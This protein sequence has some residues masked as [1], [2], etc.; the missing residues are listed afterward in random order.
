MEAVNIIPMPVARFA[1]ALLAAI[2]GIASISRPTPPEAK[3]TKRP[4][5]IVILADDLGFSDIGSYGG[6]IRTPNL[7]GLA[8]DGVRMSQFYN[9]ARCCPT[10]AS[11]LTG[12]YP[13]Q[14][15]MGEM[16]QDR[17]L[18]AYRGEINDKCAT[19]AEVLRE[20]G[21]RTGMAGK[22]H[23]T[24]LNI[25]SLPG[26]QQKALMN[27]EADGPISPTKA[28][29][30]FNR[31]FEEHWGTIPGVDSF[32]DPYGLVHNETTLRPAGKNFY[33]TDFITQHSVGMID[34]F[35]LEKGK[36]FFLYV[37][38]TAPHWPIQAKQ[39]DIDRYKGVYDVGWDR[40]RENRY[41]R[42]LK[43]GLI[44][45]DWKLSP[46]AFNTG[47]GDRDSRVN[48]W[49]DAPNKDWEAGRM[50]AYAAMVETM[51]QGIGRIMGELRKKGVDRNTIVIFLSDNGACQENV[52]PNWY[53]IPSKTRDGRPIRVGNEASFTPG[54][55]ETVY[56]SYGP[57]WANASNTPFRRFKHFTEEG[58]I[59]TPFIVRWPD[60]RLERGRIDK[61]DVGHIIDIV[62]TILEATG[63]KYPAALKGKPITPLEGK[64]LLPVL[65]GGKI[66]R[67]LLFWEH[68]DNRA[69][70]RG[71]WKIVSP[72][73][74]PWR[75]F[76]LAEDR[77]ELND[78][79]NQHPEIK[80]DLIAAYEAWSKRVGATPRP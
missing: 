78:L 76:N 42:Q 21:Y 40:I 16:N 14:A 37:A 68:E 39:K 19:V 17:G 35:T 10:R 56:Q 25:A 22:W 49:A 24:H 48:P 13:H 67:G 62:P 9:M 72:H 29:W 60:G 41:A 20:Q 6:E 23:L 77:T 50:A 43:L 51:D 18:P 65:K 58:G 47:M 4:N 53:D 11:L 70:R 32:F 63:S 80:A 38:Y 26:P 79:S 57:M 7:D 34:Q 28:N 52:Q 64:S 69:A 30:P 54:S 33:Y 2:G 31:G 46:R 66:D 3:Q 55:D 75:L 1:S 74:E 36:P 45:P 15:G 27:F 59:S 44:K 61:D 8:K 73:G 5:V 12:L 71:D